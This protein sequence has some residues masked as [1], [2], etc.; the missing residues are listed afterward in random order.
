MSE[1]PKPKKHGNFLKRAVAAGRRQRQ[2]KKDEIP[3]ERIERWAKWWEWHIMGLSPAKIAAREPGPYSVKR[4]EEGLSKYAALAADPLSRDGRLIRS[5]HLTNIMKTKAI[6][7]AQK[8]EA[9]TK[10]KGGIPKTVERETIDAH[11][12]V[13]RLNQTTYERA[14]KEVRD[15]LKFA[16][17]CEKYLATLHGILMLNNDSTSDLNTIE[18]SFDGLLVSPPKKEE[19]GDE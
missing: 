2:L 1:P 9:E 10:A 6:D 18:V 5:V 8:L 11:G 13:V 15:W 7:A 12:N 16:L 4:V 14:D 17:E 19:D 3:P